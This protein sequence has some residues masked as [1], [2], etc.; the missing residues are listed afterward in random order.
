MERFC[1]LAGGGGGG[2]PAPGA[3]AIWP[4]CIGAPPPVIRASS[5]RLRSSVMLSPAPIIRWCLTMCRLGFIGIAADVLA[6]AI[7]L[8]AGA[9]AVLA[10]GEAGVIGA[11]CANA[12]AAIANTAAIATPFKRCFML[13]V[14]CGSSGFEICGNGVYYLGEGFA[15]SG[16]KQP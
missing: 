11:F 15:A 10:G 1:H 14:L 16:M 13:V 12:G 3:G 6:G 7:V 4:P 8:A 5:W 2:A 9:G